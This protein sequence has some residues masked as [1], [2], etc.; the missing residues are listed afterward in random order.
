MLLLPLLLLLLLLPLLLLLLTG[1]ICSAA[2]HPTTRRLALKLQ[3]QVVAGPTT[4]SDLPPF[5]WSAWQN[6]NF[7]H[8]G[9]PTTFNFDWETMA[10]EDLPIDW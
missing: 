6:L 1:P 9:Q 2:A 4:S 3:S 10:P 7:T 8:H 5:S